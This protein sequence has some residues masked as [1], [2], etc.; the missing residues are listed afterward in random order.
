MWVFGFYLCGFVCFYYN[1]Y[2]ENGEGERDI[3]IA[4]GRY[5]LHLVQG[6]RG[7]DTV[8]ELDRLTSEDSGLVQCFDHRVWCHG[9]SS[10]GMKRE[11]KIRKG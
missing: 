5:I 4:P 3:Y 6:E 11:V 8:T 9:D 10:L 1:C 2:L 7:M